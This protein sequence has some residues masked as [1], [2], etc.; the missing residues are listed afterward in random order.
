MFANRIMT[1]TITTTPPS[2]FWVLAFNAILPAE[3]YNFGLAT[4][5][6]RNGV[7][8][9]GS[10]DDN[11]FTTN[12]LVVYFIFGV[13]T[14]IFITG[15]L[16]HYCFWRPRYRRRRNEWSLEGR[17]NDDKTVS[18]EEGE[19]SLE[20]ERQQESQRNTAGGAPG[21]IESIVVVAGPLL[22]SESGDTNQ[23]SASQ[24]YSEDTF[25]T[26]QES[27][28]EPSSDQQI[29]P[30][31]VEEESAASQTVGKSNAHGIEA[32]SAQPKPGVEVQTKK[33]SSATNT[34]GDEADVDVERPD[35]S[36][37]TVKAEA[38]PQEVS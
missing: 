6:A 34:F 24:E 37:A 4:A 23:T 27:V 38:N 12:R 29:P 13:F 28:S 17:S 26:E 8:S 22:R 30:E 5:A 2:L 21:G 19:G 16:L 31:D 18:M 35:D 3:A 7:D 25:S 33:N 15:C 11:D 20:N 10:D 32:S 36:R 1:K 14:G 9:R